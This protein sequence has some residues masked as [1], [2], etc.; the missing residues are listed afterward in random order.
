VPSTVLLFSPD[1]AAREEVR[2]ALAA[3]GYAVTATAEG[4]DAREQAGQHQL[5]VVDVTTMQ[6]GTADFIRVV[7]REAQLAELPVLAIAETDDIEERIGLIEAGADEVIARP[8]DP[9]ELEG[10]MLALELRLP[11]AA[12]GESGAPPTD[13]LRDAEAPEHR[14]IAVFGPKGGT[15]TTTIAVNVALAL[16]NHRPDAVAIVD[17]DAQFG[18]VATYLLPNVP[19]RT[20]AEIMQDDQAL[21]DPETLRSYAARVDPGLHVYPAASSPALAELATLPKV[22]RMLKTARGSYELVVIDAGSHLDDRALE[23]LESADVVIVP[24]RPEMAALRAVVGLTGYLRDINALGPGTMFVVNHLVPREMV[25]LR[26]IESLLGARVAVEIPPDPYIFLKAVNEGVPVVRAA[27]KTVA[28]QRLSRLAAMTL[29]ESRIVER[30]A[31][32]RKPGRRL[33]GF[34]GSR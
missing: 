30:R 28:A 27:P 17:L 22:E 33:L 29:G 21:D 3:G 14:T 11:R 18:Q 9:R 6:G 24:V 4:A 23:V 8:F 34:R 12:G 20:L 26:D 7:R 13:A 32:E 5:L 19:K 25:K 15:G 2:A 10:R 1:A 31:P 16:A